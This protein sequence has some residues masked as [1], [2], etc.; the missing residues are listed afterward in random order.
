MSLKGC[1]VL[2]CDGMYCKQNK[3]G[4][5]GGGGGHLLTTYSIMGYRPHDC[6]TSREDTILL[7]LLRR[8]HSYASFIYSFMAAAIF[9][10]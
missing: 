7:F 10:T 3:R 8:R 9:I 5:G 6:M 4:R 1:D 2:S